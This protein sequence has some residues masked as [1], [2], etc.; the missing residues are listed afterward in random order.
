ML[1]SG[2]GSSAGCDDFNAPG[3]ATHGLQVSGFASTPYNV[4]VG[5]TDFN[6]LKKRFHLLE[7]QQRLYHSCFGP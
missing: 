5:G 1:S 4:A 3:P 6:D 7:H 2:D